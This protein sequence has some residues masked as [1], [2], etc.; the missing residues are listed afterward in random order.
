MLK[1]FQHFSKLRSCPQERMF[2]G[3][4]E[5]SEIDLAVGSGWEVKDVIGGAQEWGTSVLS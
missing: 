3:D 1:S 4:L 5:S 2:W